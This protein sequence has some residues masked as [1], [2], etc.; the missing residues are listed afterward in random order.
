[1]KK[2]F[3][4]QS[5]FDNKGCYSKEQVEKLSFIAQPEITIQNI[6]NSEIPLKDK[7][8]FVRNKCELTLN[9]KRLLAIGCAKAV[10][11]IYENKYPNDNR[12]RTGT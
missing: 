11:S 10:L 2:I 6:A 7:F 5:I 9:Q 3:T 4:P 8:W 12:D 1:M